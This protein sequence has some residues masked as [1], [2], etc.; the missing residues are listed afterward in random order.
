MCFFNPAVGIS[1]AWQSSLSRTRAQSAGTCCH[2][3]SYGTF[4]G[5]RAQAQAQSGKETYILNGGHYLVTPWHQVKAC[6]EAPLEISRP[7]LRI[8]GWYRRVRRADKPGNSDPQG[9][10]SLFW[11]SHAFVAA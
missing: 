1:R 4:D 5:V 9:Y 11:I 3:S 6:L 2:Y 8:N 10:V 7:P